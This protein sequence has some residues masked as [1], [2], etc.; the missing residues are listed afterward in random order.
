[1]KHIYVGKDKIL[2]CNDEE[3]DCPEDMIWHRD[4]SEIFFAGVMAGRLT[5]NNSEIEVL[6]NEKE[7]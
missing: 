6:D 7:I 2:T 3:C 5:K 4:L 1:M